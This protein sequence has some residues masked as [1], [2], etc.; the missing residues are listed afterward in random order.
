MEK[1]VTKKITQAEAVM[2]LLRL[3]KKH[4]PFMADFSSLLKAHASFYEYIIDKAINDKLTMEDF[5][6]I[7]Q[8][9]FSVLLIDNDIDTTTQKAYTS[10]KA[11]ATKWK[12][13]A[14]WSVGGLLLLATLDKQDFSIGFNVF[15]ISLWNEIYRSPPLTT[16]VSPWEVISSTR[17]KTLSDIASKLRQYEV[18]LKKAG[19]L[20][21]YPR[22]LRKHAHWW[23]EHYVEKK[24]Y[25]HIDFGDKEVDPET[26]KRKVWEFSNLIGINNN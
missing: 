5:L 1:L 12:L 3:Y 13:N 9:W 6:T 19:D 16:T 21:K 4:P 24:E 15:S 8:R 18:I 25:K 26:I 22:S 20:R 23:F 14:P 17:R 10:L 7:N 2:L 11:L